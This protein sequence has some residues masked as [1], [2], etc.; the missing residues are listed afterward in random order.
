MLDR[1]PEWLLRSKFSG[2]ARYLPTV[3]RLAGIFVALVGIAKF[4]DRAAEIRDFRD[5]GVPLPGVAVTV[6]GIVEVLGG[7]LV[8]VGFLTRPAALAVAG[9]LLG[10]LLT[11]GINEGGTFHLVV[12]PALM[13]VM[14]LLVWSGSGALA[15]DDHLLARRAGTTVRS[16]R[17]DTPR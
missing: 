2:A 11:A 13:L 1:I 16:V 14:V 15:V 10:A 8:A 5:F 17:P 3:L 9:N 6:A 12:G 7:L 4:T